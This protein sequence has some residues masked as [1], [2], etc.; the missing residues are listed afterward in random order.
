MEYAGPIEIRKSIATLFIKLAVL[1][2]VVVLAYLFIRLSKYWVFRQF[3]TDEN[4]H[5]LNF[6]LGIMV[7]IAI[8]II[9]AALIAY[10]VL[11]WYFEYY[12]I[13]KNVIVHKSGVL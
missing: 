7:F 3:F 2:L 9:Q 6:W 10:L 4:C 1:Q 8:M 5:D 13:R 11:T 12:E